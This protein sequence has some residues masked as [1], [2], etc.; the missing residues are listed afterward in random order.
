MECTDCKCFQDAGQFDD[1][2][3]NALV[4][5]GYCDDE[6]NN[7]KCNFDG[8]DCCGPCTFTDRCKV[9]EC[10]ENGNA[11]QI[12]ALVGN[13]ICNDETNIRD[14]HYDG[15]DCCAPIVNTQTCSDCNCNGKPN[16]LCLFGSL[17]KVIQIVSTSG[18]RTKKLKSMLF[19]QDLWN[20]EL[21]TTWKSLI[22]WPHRMSTSCLVIFKSIHWFWIWIC[23]EN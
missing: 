7:E 8:G 2:I 18:S 16:R 14:C 6:R 17:I 11:T 23:K 4:G 20:S 15:F 12:N 9:C 19:H 5:D 3:Q 21:E 1:T 22:G 13:G 10:H